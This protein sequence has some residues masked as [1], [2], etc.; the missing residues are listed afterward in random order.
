MHIDRKTLRTIFLGVAGCIFLYWLLTEAGKVKDVL[1]FFWNIISPFVIGAGLAFVLNVPMRGI[2]RHLGRVKK[3][4]MRR[5]LALLL[6]MVAILLV[7]F[8]IIRLLLPQVIDTVATLIERLP[9][10]FENVVDTID[11]LIQDN[12]TLLEWL[13]N[14]TDFEDMDWSGLVDKV[15]EF[16]GNSVT[17]IVSG[18][19]AAIGNL[20]S[21]IFNGVI[22]LVFA[23]YCLARKEILARQVRRLMYAFLPEKFCD[24]AIRIMRLTNKTFSN[25]ISGQC[26]EAC[27]LGCM[28]AVAMLI[29]R[30]PYIPLVSVLIGI[31]A[32]IPIVGA[33]VG[34]GLGAFFIFVDNPI[35]A[36][37]F[38]VMFLIIQQIENN[39]VYPKVVGTSV[40]LPGMWVLL[41]VTVGGELLGVA[42][43]LMMI[44]LFSV[45]YTILRE[46]TTRRLEKRGI[47]EEKLKVQPPE[48]R[49]RLA[50]TR[51]RVKQKRE[52][53]KLI[54]KTP[55][56]DGED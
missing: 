21:G 44:P 8:I 51:R 3:N 13:Q 41:A 4:T 11:K 35:R 23:I 32:L 47:D 25:F 27:I 34:C 10:F 6:T 55:N 18:I 28:F 43:M 2:E 31:T 38:I 56:N 33:F 30:M 19:W 22:A 39:V 29:F 50:E 42:G 9:A 26:L 45:L 16:L 46:L 24:T 48:V 49:N 1:Q 37:W 17:V 5:A 12:P 36:L 54:K 20:Y 53:R 40:G 52:L 14:N 15:V 7:I